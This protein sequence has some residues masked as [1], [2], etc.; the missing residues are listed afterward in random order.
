VKNNTHKYKLISVRYLT[1]AIRR[2]L[3]PLENKYKLIL[4]KNNI[5]NVTKYKRRSRLVT[6][7]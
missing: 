5:L 2:G 3:E 4:Y 7:E 1:T 6:S